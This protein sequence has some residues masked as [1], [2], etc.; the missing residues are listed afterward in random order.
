MRAWRAEIVGCV[1]RPVAVSGLG[2]ASRRRESLVW[3]LLVMT[4]VYS[5]D[6]IGSKD[7]PEGKR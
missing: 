5:F 6:R 3:L 7:F 4:M 1:Y 2:R